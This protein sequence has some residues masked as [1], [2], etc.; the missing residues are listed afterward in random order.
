MRA[1]KI[2]V[3]FDQVITAQMNTWFMQQ[4]RCAIAMLNQLSEK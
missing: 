1:G 2:A 4:E 3:K